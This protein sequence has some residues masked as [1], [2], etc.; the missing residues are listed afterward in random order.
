M[1]LYHFICAFIISHDEILHQISKAEPLNLYL[2]CLK[3]ATVCKP[4]HMIIDRLFHGWVCMYIQPCI[5][6]LSP[7]KSYGMLESGGRKFT[8]V[9]AISKPAL[10]SLTRRFKMSNEEIGIACLSFTIQIYKNI[11][12]VLSAPLRASPPSIYSPI[13]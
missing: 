5:H 10:T 2:F 12:F 4:C 8:A 13:T 6:L 9:T 1:N 11:L 3:N 7:L